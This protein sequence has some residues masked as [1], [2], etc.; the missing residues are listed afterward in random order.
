MVRGLDLFRA[1]FADF[2]EQYILIGG[3]AATLVM[4]DAD[5][6]FRA[7]KDL[8]IV[9]HVEALT[10]EFGLAFWAFLREGHYASLEQG[11]TEK[12]KYYRFTRPADE[13]YPAMLEL[14]SRAA[15]GLIMPPAC[16]LTPIPMDDAVSS[17]SAILLNDDYYRFV[18]DGRRELGGVICV[19][20]D[21]LIALK[22]SAWIDLSARRERGET[23]DA[24]HVR[25]HLND[26]LR[27]SQLLAPATRITSSLVIQADLRQFLAA[28]RDDASIEP[29]QL[30]LGNVSRITLMERIAAAF[31][32]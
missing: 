4:A 30:G 31:D 28:V 20:E 3:T 7:T 27:L 11:G 9:L 25:K 5:L 8:D 2:K 24:K 29:N 21:R 18:I 23:V 10:A 1:K 17:L 19:G 16:A 22:A 14:F 13:R 12:P 26:V 6:M 32:L 15:D